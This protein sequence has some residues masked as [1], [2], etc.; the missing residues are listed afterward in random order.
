MKYAVIV[1]RDKGVVRP[2]VQD[3]VVSCP[4]GAEPEVKML[5]HGWFT[6]QVFR[7]KESALKCVADE[8]AA[9]EMADMDG[10]E[11]RKLCEAIMVE[12]VVKFGLTRGA[13]A[14]LAGVSSGT[15]RS[16]T[17]PYTSDRTPDARALT[18]LV[19][20]R[21]RLQS[22]ETMSRLTLPDEYST[23]RGREKSDRK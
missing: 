6:R 2:K 21:Q 7:T 13:V 5:R 12:L 4:D 17:A 14:R 11:R 15:L 10:A 9:A 3:E 18:R 22:L 16:W 8:K 19:I 1:T 23:R 20:L